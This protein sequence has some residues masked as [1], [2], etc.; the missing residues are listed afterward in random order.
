MGVV[1]GRERALSPRLR[2]HRAAAEP[3]VPSAPNRLRRAE[4]VAGARRLWPE[5]SGHVDG[6]SPHSCHGPAHGW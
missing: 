3:P 6:P 1:R 5:P 4:P 2:P